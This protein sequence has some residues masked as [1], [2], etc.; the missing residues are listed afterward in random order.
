MNLRTIVGAIGLSVFL[1]GCPKTYGEHEKAAEDIMTYYADYCIARECSREE[2]QILCRMLKP[3]DLYFKRFEVH[4]A[5]GE[6][7][8][9]IREAIASTLSRCD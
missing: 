7:A 5:Y 6:R 3:Y 1:S 9:K 2:N 4:K 8:K